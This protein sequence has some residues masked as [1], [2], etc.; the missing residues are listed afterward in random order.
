MAIKHA[1]FISF[2][3]GPGKDSLF[4]QYFYDVFS[5]HLASINKSLSI[6]K[7]DVPYCENCCQGDD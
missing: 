4:S 3:R 5:Q 1:F 7:Y 2:P 6:F